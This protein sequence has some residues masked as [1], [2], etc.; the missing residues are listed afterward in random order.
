MA[1]ELTSSAFA[2]GKAIPRHY[3][4][5]GPNVSVPLEW[6]DPPAGAAGFALIADDPDAPAG[7]WVHW[8]LYGLP[9]QARRLPEGVP[10]TKTLPDGSKQGVND[11]GRIGYGGPCPPRGPAHR[12]FFTLYAVDRMIELP[13]GAAK[14]QLLDAIKGH[15]LGKTQLMGTYQRQ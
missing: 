12:Y 5:D 14:A 4:C 8:V 1:F 13:P 15:T 3:T 11:F 6:G 9:G 2:Q 10:A 7:T